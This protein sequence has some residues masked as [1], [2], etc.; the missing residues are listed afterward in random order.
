[1]FNIPW[2]IIVIEGFYLDSSIRLPSK[3]LTSSFGGS[4]SLEL[5]RKAVNAVLGRTFCFGMYTK[6]IL[7]DQVF[8]FVR[9]GLFLVY[10]T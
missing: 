7:D 10:C 3:L 9:L 6:L 1:M 8:Y 5:T 4:I 2:T